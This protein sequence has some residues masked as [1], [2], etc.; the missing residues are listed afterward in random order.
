MSVEEAGQKLTF[1]RVKM[2]DIWILF[3]WRL[4]QQ[5]AFWSLGQPPT[6]DTHAKWMRDTTMDEDI[7]I[8]ENEILGS[9]AVLSA[10]GEEG[11]VGI[12]VNPLLRGQG[13]GKECIKFL[14]RRYQK[15]RATV[16]VGNTHSLRLFISCGFTLTDAE[17]VKHRPC[18]ILEWGAK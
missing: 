3:A 8:A 10:K 12:T 1:R 4:E 5:T 11:E 7:Y 17:I 16:I 15:L 2:S 13:H 6:I 14:Q 9:V 18:V